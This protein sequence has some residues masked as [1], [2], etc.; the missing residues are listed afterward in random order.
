MKI[1]IKLLPVNGGAFNCLPAREIEIEAERVLANDVTLPWEFNPHNVR[2]WVIGNE[3]G[4]LGA[5]WASHEQDA[6]DTLVDENL[7]DSLIVEEADWSEDGTRLGNAGEPCDLTNVW[8]QLADLTDC[9]LLCAF[10]EA[11]GAAENNLDK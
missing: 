3:F 2:L 5:V 10:A 4:A 6:L 8:I 1:K 11:R 9:R 7:G